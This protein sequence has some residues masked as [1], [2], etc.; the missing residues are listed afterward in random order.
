VHFLYT[1]TPLVGRSSYEYY[2]THGA[3]YPCFLKR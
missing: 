1:V 2:L 3:E